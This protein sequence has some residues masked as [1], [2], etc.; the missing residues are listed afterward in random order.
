[1]S[2]LTLPAI[3]YELPAEPIEVPTKHVVVKEQ[4]PKLPSKTP[5]NPTVE[6]ERTPENYSIVRNSVRTG[7]DT[8]LPLPD[9][10]P[11]IYNESGFTQPAPPAAPE[12][13]PRP[14]TRPA[15]TPAPEVPP[16]PIPT[17][18][19]ST[20]PNA[21][22]LPPRKP[23][24]NQWSRGPPLRTPPSGNKPNEFHYTRDSHKMIVYF[25]P[26]PKPIAAP[27][28]MPQRFLIYTPP[29]PHLLKPAEG[30]K[31][32]KRSKAKR[33]WQQEIKKAKTYEGKTLSLKG[34]HSK[35]MRGI[36]WATA[37]IK[38]TDI[39][40]LNRVPRKEVQT[41]LLLHPPLSSSASSPTAS[42]SP[43]APA[44]L[45]T[46]PSSLTSH[47]SS[48]S[49][50]LS[51]P[52]QF[53]H[54]ILVTRHRALTHTLISSALLAPSLIIDT[55][56]AVI[57]PFGGLFEIDLIWFYSCIRGYLVSRS[58]LR[59]LSPSHFALPSSS[60]NSKT[61][62][63]PPS[64]KE[65]HLRFKEMENMKVLE[66]YVAEMCHKRDPARFAS[67][68]V[69][70]TEGEVLRAMGWESVQRGKGWEDA[71]WQEREM[72]DDLEGV[73]K[74]GAK[75]WAKWCKKYEKKPEKAVKR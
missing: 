32:G 71:Q 28:D 40:F 15:P 43:S 20:T 23:G 10:R 67:A 53:T 44:S 59:R 4:P 55:F 3:A 16:R 37:A 45:N 33:Y 26:L 19:T 41:L 8:P 39:T 30:V 68:G 51:L 9:S 47:K 54:Q 63:T 61:R 42:L 36:V 12:V 13:P 24:P 1:M 7:T 75:S 52:Q 46:T 25:I 5:P 74:K 31:E 58:L 73:T 35:T 34:L 72:R 17:T 66:R 18:T 50:P 70:P 11:G 65:L 14:I 27:D 21:P 62:A 2:Q 69:P 38:S 29:A 48:P 56:A 6:D 49:P 22:D 57:W 64:D 60:T